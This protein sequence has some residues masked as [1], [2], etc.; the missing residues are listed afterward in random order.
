[1]SFTFG[2]VSK[3]LTKRIYPPIFSP[4][5]MT[6]TSSFELVSQLFASRRISFYDCFMK[7]DAIYFNFWI[8]KP[9][10]DIMTNFF[11]CPI[12]LP[13]LM[14][15]S[16]DFKVVRRIFLRKKKPWFGTFRVKICLIFDIK[17][18]PKVFKIP[19]NKNS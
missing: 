1:M 18:K 7:F 12:L 5:L 11:F 6:F 8:G 4:S 3:L 16:F 19:K 2:L 13:N 17:F 9:T 15:F 10:F 14:S